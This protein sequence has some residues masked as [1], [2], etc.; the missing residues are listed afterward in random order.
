MISPVRLTD[1]AI[2]NLKAAPARYEL[3]DPGARGLYVIVHP[4]GRTSFAVRYRFAGQPKKLTLQAGVSLSAARKLCADALHEVAQG[5]D[6]SEAKKTAKAKTEAAAVN[7]VQYVCEQ[8]LQREGKN[9]RTLAPRKA[10]L[11]RLVY[12]AL[13]KRLIGDVKRSDINRMLDKIEDTSGK[14]S[15]DLALQ[16]LRRA[17][18]WHAVRDDDFRS[19]IISGMGRYDT[20]ANARSRVLNDDE[21]R[22]I[23]KASEA[24]GYFGALIRFL[25]L[26]GARRQEAAGLQW[27]EIDGDVWTLPA[28]RNKSMIDFTR[29]LSKTAKAIIDAQ[30]RIGA[31]PYIFTFNG[32]RPI[33]FG[34]CKREF[35]K[36][37]DVKNW[38]LHDLRRTARTLLSR[39]GVNAD[40]GEMCLGHKL[41]GVRG[42]YDRHTFEPEMRAAFERLATTIENIVRPTPNVTPMRKV[43]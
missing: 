3:P 17:M 37:C 19:P 33:S 5:H 36:N 39:A 12:P 9:L 1:I 22:K 27:P 23:W 2:R 16:Y 8:F 4:S 18:N 25:L 26:T 10:L 24:A 41:R 29:P 15:A 21:L 13:G 35:T 32:R 43:R 14:R 6:P 7:T 31:S 28:A 20:V 30:P 11:K 34:R 38:R 42:I 40:I